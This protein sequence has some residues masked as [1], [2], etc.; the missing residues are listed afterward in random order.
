MQEIR[1]Q[2][3]CA[4]LL[5]QSC[6]RPAKFLEEFL[7]TFCDA[8]LNGC[9][10]KREVTLLVKQYSEV[11]SVFLAKFFHVVQNDKY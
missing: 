3:F 1:T 8:Y 7:R 5:G 4:P 2:Q 6:A 11:R 9:V 10:L